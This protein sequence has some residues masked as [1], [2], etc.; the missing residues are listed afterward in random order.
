M[1]RRVT[2]SVDESD[3]VKIWD[4]NK[5]VLVSTLNRRY[6]VEEIKDIG[7]VNQ[8]NKLAARDI[9]G[10]TF[11]NLQ[12]NLQNLSFDQE[13][14]GYSKFMI[15]RDGKHMI[16]AR[17]DME[18]V[19]IDLKNNMNFTKMVTLPESL[20]DMKFVCNGDA[21]IKADCYNELE[22]PDQENQFDEDFDEEWYKIIYLDFDKVEDVS[23]KTQSTQKTS[24]GTF[25]NNG[26]RGEYQLLKI[27]DELTSF[28]LISN[29]GFQKP[30]VFE[31]DRAENHE[32]YYFDLESH[33]K[34]KGRLYVGTSKGNCF[35]V[36][37]EMDTKGTFSMD[38][39]TV[40]QNGFP[41]NDFDKKS[42][43]VDKISNANNFNTNSNKT[44]LQNLPAAEFTVHDF[45]QFLEEEIELAIFTESKS[46][47]PRG[48]EC[49]VYAR[50]KGEGKWA[51][52][53]FNTRH[54]YN[55]YESS[56]F[57]AN[58]MN[59]TQS[60]NKIKFYL[61]STIG[62]AIICYDKKD[63]EVAV[64]Q[65]MKK[66]TTSSSLICYSHLQNLFYICHKN[67]IQ[68]WNE[69][70]QFS[71]YNI[72]LESEALQISVAENDTMQRLLVYDD[73]NYYEIDLVTLN[74]RRRDKIIG[75]DSQ[76]R[77]M[78]F[79]LNLFRRN[80]SF[81][82]PFFKEELSD[83]SFIANM[84]TL[85]LKEFPF[86]HLRRCFSKED[87]TGPILRFADYYFKKLAEL[88]F[89]DTLYGPLNPLF[90]AIYH[91]DMRL[92]ENLLDQYR[93]PKQIKEY[94]SPLAFSFVYN[95]N[96]AVK[97]FCDRLIKRNYNVSF[98]L[99]DF[100]YLLNSRF[101][102]CH[103]L[104]A[105]IPSEP[106]LQ[107]FPRLL[108]M[109]SA[110]QLHYVEEVGHLLFSLKNQERRLLS[111]ISKKK[112]TI[113]RKKTLIPTKKKEIGQGFT[114]SEVVSFQI[115]FKYSYKVGTPDSVRFLDTFSQ[116]TTEE[117]ILSEWKEVVTH[118]WRSHRLVHILMAVL[119][120][121]FAVFTIL[122][123]VFFQ[124]TFIF[125]AVSLS[126]ICFFI[127]YE[128]LQ[129]ISYSAFKIKRYLHC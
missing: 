61:V 76:N 101:S 62:I 26:I 86:H 49:F 115:P 1:R 43:N 15:L 113:T 96:S 123:V 51:K 54:V 70:L 103:K 57:L 120:W 90:F 45:K 59:N 105:T 52:T 95:Y 46:R 121:I 50:Y 117:F 11:W 16:F 36:N 82:I 72:D 97:V 34:W 74:F 38:Q 110:V 56:Y 48:K 107:N 112:K 14:I 55:F 84:E 5:S 116:S 32:P 6:T 129:V 41:C 122:S 37:F 2:A 109:K 40:F 39:E 81:T 30:F 21:L 60:E 64:L 66:Y 124:K 28:N 88:N 106:T 98:S 8:G 125:E 114:K 91:N 71:T 63:H 18:L 27:K 108:Y 19:K 77:N 93:Y 53:Q 80:H 69:T 42:A 89:E 25:T 24:E 119:Y 68:V 94:W 79:N 102:Y 73:S 10:I 126:F 29:K 75:L 104:I 92:L 7:V 127:L 87:Y 31:N 58:R 128:I 100:K 118:K 67:M 13:D 17:D 99:F 35:I 4:L 9:R 47:N 65:Y 78:P 83:I 111:Q 23:G 33:V 44:V 3:I 12:Q 85:N 22:S 20:Y